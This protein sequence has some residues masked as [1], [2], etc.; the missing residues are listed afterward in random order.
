MPRPAA[1]LDRDALLETLALDTNTRRVLARA[2]GGRA[3][4]GQAIEFSCTSG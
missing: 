2:I 3:Q 4:P 1:H